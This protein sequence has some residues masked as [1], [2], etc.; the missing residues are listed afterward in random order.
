MDK[1]LE[2][3]FGYMEI[4]LNA[5][6]HTLQG[7]RHDIIQFLTVAGKVDGPIVEADHHM[8]RF[9]LAR[10]KENGYTR[11]TVARKLSAVRSFLNFLQREGDLEKG[12]W[13]NVSRPLQEKRLPQFFYHHEVTALLEAPDCGTPLGYRDRTIFELL[14]ASGLRVGEL[15]GLEINSCDLEERLVRVTGKGS[16]ERIVPMGRIAAGF[17]REYLIRI[18]PQLLSA[19]GEGAAGNRRLFLNHR[20]GSLTDR[21]VRYIFDK[22]VRKISHKEGLTPH[23][24]RHSFATHLLERG[25]DLRV[26]QELLGHAS[27]STTQIYTHVSKGH[28]REIYRR[29]HPRG[30]DQGN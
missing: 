23:S 27:I 9:Y 3:F 10:L 21:G 11:S 4:E 5:S 16:K 17:L 18:R 25:A 15:T 22:Y 30:L 13:S 2:R 8:L 20:G 1:Q 29:A 26:V 14:Y 24:L 12:S 6:P 19:A 7:Y 28:L